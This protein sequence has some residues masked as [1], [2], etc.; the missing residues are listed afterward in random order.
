[1]SEKQQRLFDDLPDSS[2]PTTRYEWTATVVFADAPVGQFDY[3]IGPEL[4]D[5]VQPGM[6]LWVP[7]GRANRRRI[8]YC[9]AVQR[10]QQ[11][12]RALKPVQAVVDRRPLLSPVMLRLTQWMA[13]YYLCHWGQV[14]EAVLPAPVR[15]RKSVKT[16]TVLYLSEE[17][18]GQIDRL[19]LSEKQRRVL[20]T[21]A[22]SGKPLTASQLARAARCTVS[23]VNTLRAK[24]LL[25]ARTRQA[26]PPTEAESTV[27]SAVPP[28]LNSDQR[29]A[30]QAIGQALQGGTH[31]TILIHGVTGSGKT[32]VYIRAIEEVV[33]S[34]RQAIV[35]VPEIS[36]TPQTVDRFRSRFP[37]VA[38]LHSHLSD[39]DRHWHWQQIAE[40]R[41]PVVVGARSAIFAPTP[42]LGIIVVD[43]EHE[44]SFKQETAP[45]YHARRVAL[46][47]AE[48]EG[49]PLVLGSATPSL[50][51]WHSARTGRYRMVRLPRRVLGRPLPEVGV[52]DLRSDQHLRSAR[53][54]ISRQLHMAIRQALDDGG[55]VILMLNRRGF[56]THIQCPACGLVLRCP[57]CDI[58]LT[59]H[60]VG[61][62]A[63]CHY[64]DYRTDVPN[65]CPECKYA[66]IRFGGIGTQ[67]LE[68][69]LLARFPDAPCLRMDTDTMQ[70]RG[71]HQR[72]LAAFHRGEA[73][74]LLGT[75]MI[76]KGLDFPNVTLVGV[77]N[78]D[79]ALHLPDFRAAER[80][81]QLV[82]QVA[83][84]TGRGERG[85]RVLVQ[86][87]NPEHPAIQ[88]AAHHDY[89]AF[90]EHELPV[91]ELFSY[92]P[93][94]SMIRIVVRSNEARA[95]N[96]FAA[97]MAAALGQLLQTQRAEARLLGPAPCPIARLRGKHRFQIQVQGPHGDRLRAAVRKAEQM[98]HPPSGVEWIA[99]MDP[100]D[101]L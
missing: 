93:F 53:G 95:A 57:D 15:Q 47:R 40:G 45:R 38:L 12:D 18:R 78:A 39:G 74:I 56:S 94:A 88:A 11:H 65:Q 14:L 55:Q 66:G 68:A 89:R 69:E 3:W 32:E 33:R 101:M 58:A 90:A 59:H 30:L 96:R 81:F 36:L 9:V 4:A 27:V 19:K 97:E 35:L 7:L 50:E 16:E 1:M 22:A 75:Q 71:A 100:I 44:P 60:R 79:T 92:P 91:R 34:G 77:V 61:Q 64:C 48:M 31:Q 29:A 85:G 17:I 86:T 70:G 72:A 43:E 51:S 49:V 52:I 20:Q 13:E 26:A 21:L 2:E 82:T 6:R 37:A 63:I 76:A 80:T 99:D 41:V 54:A 8:A 5:R 98:L 67:R 84:R 73:K 46:V 10:G 25:V 83:G 23:P 62:S 42:R 28:Q 24:G 87:F